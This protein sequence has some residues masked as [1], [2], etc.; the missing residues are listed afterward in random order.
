VLHGSEERT[1]DPLTGKSSDIALLT[2][3]HIKGGVAILASDMS[4]YVYAFEKI[5]QHHRAT[6]KQIGQL[7][8]SKDTNITATT[9]TQ[10]AYNGKT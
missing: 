3:V 1:I 6:L 2:M 4:L 9:D 8:H 5:N 7:Q 10:L